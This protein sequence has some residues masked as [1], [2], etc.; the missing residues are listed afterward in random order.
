MQSIPAIQAIDVHAHYGRYE[1]KEAGPL[2]ELYSGGIE[3]VLERA[4]RANTCLTIVSPMKALMPRHNGDPVSGNSEAAAAVSGTDGVLQWVVVDPLKPETFGQADEMLK[5]PKCVGIKI[6]PEEHG[7]PIAEHAR[8][9]FE[10]AADQHAVVQTHSGEQNSLPEDF[11][12]WADRFPE[13]RLILSHLGFGWDGDPSHQVRAIQ[14]SKHGNIF[15][16]TSSMRSIASGLL[17][18]AV[19]EVG[20]SQILYGTDSP[21]YFAPMQRARVDCADMG[22]DEKRRILRDNAIDLFGLTVDD[23]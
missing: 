7:Y 3:V 4:R 6:H 23:V 14:R 16:D 11:V 9:L 17:E 1:S 21:L 18:W 20:A 13:I 19:K 10:F 8:A 22:D 5:H 15:T 2:D 12:E